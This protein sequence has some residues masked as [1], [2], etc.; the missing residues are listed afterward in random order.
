LGK[1]D[2]AVE[3]SGRAVEVRPDSPEARLICAQANQHVGQIEKAV[4]DYRW[5]YDRGQKSLEVVVGLGQCWQDLGRFEEARQVLDAFLAEQPARADVLVERGRLALREEG[6]APAQSYFR[7]AIAADSS[8]LDANR[9]LLRCLDE[10]GGS[11]EE[12]ARVAGQ[13]RQLEIQAGR[14][15]QLRGEILGA[16]SDPEPRYRIGILLLQSGQEEG[17]E[18]LATV[19]NLDPRHE[20]ARAALADYFQRTGRGPGEGGGQ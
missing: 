11:A 2:K 14:I 5:L 6:A 17:L 1:W 15:S 19:L 4:N 7:R 18:W 9:C 13:L 10:T 20:S 16:P 12:S 8:N 3:D